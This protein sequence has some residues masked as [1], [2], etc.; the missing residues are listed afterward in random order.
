MKLQPNAPATEAAAVVIGGAN[1]DHKS[2]T[3]AKPILGTSNPGRSRSSAGGVARNIAENLARMS[4][5]VA[6]VTAI[7]RDAEG[8]RVIEETAATGVVLDHAVRTSLP[9]GS[10]TALLSD[11]GELVLAVSSMESI[12][13]ITPDVIDAASNIIRRA[14]VLVLD[15]NISEAALM[16]AATIAGECGVP[17]VL[18]PVSVPKSARAASILLAGI[19]IHTITPNLDELVAL[20]GGSGETDAEICEAAAFLHAAGVDNV[21]IRQGVDGS[22]LSCA[23]SGDMRTHRIPACAASV[24]DVTGAGDAMLAGYVAALLNGHDPVFAARRGSAAAAIT[25]QSELTVSPMMTSEA[26]TAC[27]DLLPDEG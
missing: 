18:D 8:E 22:L 11:S 23:R 17:V 4:V 16:R 20:G 14:R 7:G 3:F 5:P 25:V 21:W 1:V 6:L 10:Y 2:Q 27:A 19:R 26:V 15:C 24:V 12:E 13:E 9:T